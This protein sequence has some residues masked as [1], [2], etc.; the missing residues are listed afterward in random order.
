VEREGRVEDGP[1]V[2]EAKVKA[3]RSSAWIEGVML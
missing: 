2:E 1:M 3:R